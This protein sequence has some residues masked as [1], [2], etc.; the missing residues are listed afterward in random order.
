MSEFTKEQLKEASEKI[1]ECVSEA[2]A[3]LERAEAIADEFNVGFSFSPFY[4]GG[5][6]YNP[7]ETSEYSEDHWHSSSHSC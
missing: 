1:S 4:G 6:Y 7:E 2:Y 5:G 3:A